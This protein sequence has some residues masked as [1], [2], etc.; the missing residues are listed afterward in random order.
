MSTKKASP[1][2]SKG[3]ETTGVLVGYG[4]L[5]GLKITVGTEMA[6]PSSGNSDFALQAIMLVIYP[7]ASM[8]PS[9]ASLISHSSNW[10][11]RRRASLL[12]RPREMNPETG[13]DRVIILITS[14]V[15]RFSF[16]KDCF[17]ATTGSLIM[18]SNTFWTAMTTGL[19]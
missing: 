8:Q 6:M 7:I 4:S 2:V 11:D 5:A 12:D 9:L 1:W 14:V 17:P 15:G 3:M 10:E 19:M 18:V 13:P 16:L